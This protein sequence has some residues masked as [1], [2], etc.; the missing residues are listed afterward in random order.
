[1]VVDF[2]PFANKARVLTGSKTLTRLAELIQLFRIGKRIKQCVAGPVGD[3]SAGDLFE[4]LGVAAVEPAAVRVSDCLEKGAG[5][6]RD[7]MI[8]FEIAA[9]ISLEPP[10]TEHPDGVCIKDIRMCIGSACINKG[11]NRIVL[12]KRSP[13]RNE[14]GK[15]HT[16]IGCD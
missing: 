14:R 12:D 9:L 16:C 8:Q 13:H 7:T 6:L 1:M 3:G 10:V 2:P 4:G 15:I 5:L 11:E